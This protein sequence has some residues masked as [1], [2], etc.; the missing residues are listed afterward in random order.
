MSIQIQC[1]DDGTHNYRTQRITNSCVWG[2]QGSLCG[3]GAEGGLWPLHM[4]LLPSVDG[5][6]RSPQSHTLILYFSEYRFSTSVWIHESCCLVQRQSSFF[7]HCNMN[8]IK[9]YGGGMTTLNRSTDF[10]KHKIFRH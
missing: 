7:F 8:Q 1:S 3:P 5:R 6:C 9:L 10:K 4:Q 2:M